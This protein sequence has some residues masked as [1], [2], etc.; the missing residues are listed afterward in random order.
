MAIECLPRGIH[1][2]PRLILCRPRGRIAHNC[3]ASTLVLERE[4]GLE[5][6]NILVGYSYHNN[7]VCYSGSGPSHHWSHFFIGAAGGCCLDHETFTLQRMSVSIAVTVQSHS[8]STVRVRLSVVTSPHLASPRDLETTSY[9][10]GRHCEWLPV[11]V[12]VSSFVSNDRST[13]RDYYRVL[14]RCPHPALYPTCIATV[15][16]RTSVSPEALMSFSHA[17]CSHSG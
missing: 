10:N 3:N 6:R 8:S 7:S 4:L 12:I 13:Y 9:V 2:R 15:S 5:H 16:S 1:T 14:W 17:S 11:I